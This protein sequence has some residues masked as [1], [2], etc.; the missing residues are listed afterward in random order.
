MTDSIVSKDKTSGY[1]LL[2]KSGQSGQHFFKKNNRDAKCL[3]SIIPQGLLEGKI[4]VQRNEISHSQDF[5]VN[6]EDVAK[7]VYAKEP[8]MTHNV[9]VTLHLKIQVTFL[10]LDSLY[11][12]PIFNGIAFHLFSLSYLALL[13]VRSQNLGSWASP[14]EQKFSNL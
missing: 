6:D 12:Y 4:F 8:M 14:K 5:F 10:D 3:S 11:M 13:N 9:Y 7:N 2:N 1:N